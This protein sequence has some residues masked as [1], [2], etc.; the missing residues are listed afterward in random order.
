[1][2]RERWAADDPRAWLARAKSNLVRARA[3]LPDAYL[4]DCCFD[5]QQAAEKALKAVLL[6]RGKPIPRSHDLAYLLSAL[7]EHGPI[8]ADVLAGAE[9]TQFAVVSRY[10]GTTEPVTLAEYRQAVAT[11]AAI[12]TWAEAQLHERT[13]T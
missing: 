13:E 4:E 1:M 6:R 9:L 8:P 11:A 7:E 3:V 12:V 5:A 2:S 10:P